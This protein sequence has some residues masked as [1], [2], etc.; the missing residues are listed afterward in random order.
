M[1]ERT[2]TVPNIYKGSYTFGKKELTQR[3]DD[4]YNNNLSP[5]Q[6]YYFQAS[7]DRKVY[8][9]DQHYMNRY[10]STNYEILKFVLNKTQ[11]L[12]NAV[13]GHQ[14][15]HRKASKVVPVHN[16]SNVTASQKTKIIQGAYDLDDTYNKIS[17]CF[18]E[19]GITGLALMHLWMDYR[20]DPICGDLRSEL[21]TS[22]MMMMDAFWKEKDLSDCQFIATR[23][24]LKRDMVIE[25]L[26]DM[27]EE[28]MSLAS[29]TFNDT[30]F[31]FMPQQYNVRRKGVLAYDEFWYQDSRTATFIVD[32]N[33]Y[34]SYQY[35]GP[36]EKLEELRYRFPDT[37]VTKQSIP[38]VKL[39]IMVNGVCLYDGPNPLS[40]DI[41]PY[42]PLVA[43]HDTAINNYAYRYQGLIRTGRDY[44]YLYNYR[45]QLETDL[46]AASFSGVDVEVDALVEN[47]DAFK[48]GP[49]KVRFFKKGRLNAIRDVPGANMNPVNMQFSEQIGN[50]MEASTGITPELLGA[51][52]ETDVGITTILK[53]SAS[54]TVLQKLFDNLDVFQR[55]VTRLA[56]QI[57]EKNYTYGKI[58]RMIGE[59][60]S[61]EFRD[62]VFNK[63]DCAV[64]NAPLTHTSKQM[65]FLQYYQLWKDGFPVPMEILIDLLQVQDKDKW[66]QS[67]QQQQQQQNQM[68]QQMAQAQLENQQIVNN[69]LM[70]KAKSDEAM[71]ME[72]ISKIQVD[73]AAS[74]EK[75]TQAQA[76]L[77]KATLDNL[78]AAKELK[79]MD[80]DDAYKLVEMVMMITE[81]KNEDVEKKS[82]SASV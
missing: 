58:K 28:I 34:E 74:Y 60:P 79:S 59:D 52:D 16:S 33:T 75:I 76:N 44:Q 8:A 73:K 9:G 57:I 1:M 20:N 40:I 6:Q 2:Q 31:T 71:A 29:G 3:F 7:I 42:V 12:W 30:K 65:A 21:V 53:M 82:Q 64:E 27:K 19:A 68:Q 55:N 13:G 61:P 17:D 49:G 26:P 15:K 41:Y 24:Y 78:K 69:S 18:D 70:A 67:L 39:G 80:I 51:S 14:R 22:D 32:P 10:A 45:K 23:K 47:R 50:E 36:D 81:D 4:L 77:D 62:R 37:I 48:V 54:L 38:T 11:K 72:R 43:Y 25:L 66:M 46:L 35:E 56:D 63:Y 5:W